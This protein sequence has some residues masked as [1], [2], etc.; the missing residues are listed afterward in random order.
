LKSE[1][2]AVAETPREV[3]ENLRRD[4]SDEH[5]IPGLQTLERAGMGPKPATGRL[6][7]RAGLR[8]ASSTLLPV[9][10]WG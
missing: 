3:R 1:A 4:K 7:R 10:K 9:G 2:V 5:L 6:E 8:R